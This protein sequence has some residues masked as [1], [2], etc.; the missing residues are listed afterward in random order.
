MHALFPAEISKSSLWA[1][2][3]TG[4][5]RWS[6]AHPTR[7]VDIGV[8]EIIHQSI[9]KLREA[10]SAILL[11]TADFDELFKLSDRIGVIYEGHIV[12]EGKS[13]EYTPNRLGLYMGGGTDED[14]AV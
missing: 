1:G 7:G 5:R 14:Q 3:F 12:T 4:T 2:S 11:I 6:I 8:S 9:L 10:G 13:E